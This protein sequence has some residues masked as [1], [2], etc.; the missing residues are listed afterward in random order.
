MLVI[1]GNPGVGKHTVSEK[2]AQ[3]LDLPILDLNQIAIQNKVYEKS[4]STLDVDVKKL[5]RLVK[6]LAKKNSIIVGHLAPYV[7]DKTRVSTTIILRKNPYKL[8][9][10][11]KKRKYTQKKIIENVGSEILGIIEYDSIASFGIK[12]TFQINATNLSPSQIIAKIGLITQRKSKGDKIDWLDLV[13]RKGDLAKF[14]PNK[15]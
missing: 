2:L 5:A 6:K 12:K 8:I 9:P 1:T 10:V 11:Y 3:K 15:E 7:L 4:G 14:F 13:S